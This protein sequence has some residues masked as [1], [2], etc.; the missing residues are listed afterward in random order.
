MNKKP[1]PLALIILLPFA[2]AAFSACNRQP[3]RSPNEKRY[4]FKGKVV[5]VEKDKHTVTVAHEDI[6]DY[7]PAMTM[8]FVVKDDWAFDVLV[9]G[10]HVS[11][12]Y[13]VDGTKSWLE[14]LV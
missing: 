11:A 1:F 13:V 10:D 12:V 2:L 5:V 4:D 9:P 6:K 3:A 7:M 8:P 14:E